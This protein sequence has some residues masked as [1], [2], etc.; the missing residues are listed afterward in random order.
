MLKRLGAPIPLIFI[1]AY[2]DV[3]MVVE[4]MKSGAQDFIE[5]PFRDQDLLD[6]VH[7]ALATD[8]KTREEKSTIEEIRKRLSTLTRREAD[9]MQR[10]VNG[11]S[12]KV[13]AM[14]LGLSQRTVEIHRAH[15]MEKMAV[16][17]VAMLAR[18]VQSAET[19]GS[20]LDLD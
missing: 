14:D 5:K 18:A 7:R 15:V 6:C 8:R 12:N 11:H 3:P 10:V 17:S 13:I 9:V 19:G 16:R 4:A 20:R 1:T 2:G